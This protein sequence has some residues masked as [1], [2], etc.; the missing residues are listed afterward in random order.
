[1]LS[2]RLI[3]PND[4]PY[5]LVAPLVKV[6]SAIY[7]EEKSLVTERNEYER[8]GKAAE[9][10]KTYISKVETLGTLKV[11]INNCI[12]SNLNWCLTE[13]LDYDDADKTIKVEATNFNAAIEE[14]R[15]GLKQI[16]I[17]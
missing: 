15:N 10:N 17:R 12:A 9:G 14:Y 11:K 3:D 4:G 1:M 6:L 5:I 13:G 16:S 7:L 8:K 2:K